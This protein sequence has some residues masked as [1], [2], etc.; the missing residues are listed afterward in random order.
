[1]CGRKPGA[2]GHLKIAA[3]ILSADFSN[4]ASELASVTEEV[5]WFHLD[6]MDGHFVPNLTLGPPV[7]ASLR[8][9]SDRFFDCHLMIENP[10]HYLEAFHRA[11]ADSCTVHLEVGH[12]AE[13]IALARN[14][15]MRVAVAANPD[16]P[17]DSIAP[18]LGEVDM[19]LLMTV[20]PG[21]GGQRFI[22]DVM[23]KVT[24][25]RRE[26]EQL[27]IPLDVQVDG[28][29]D[30]VTAPVAYAAG[31]NVLVAGSAIFGQPDP[32]LAADSIRKN[33]AGG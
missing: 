32:R 2:A 21:F 16:T 9:T 24:Q 33:A 29:I 11:G 10:H 3:S 28:G 25:V 5:D 7:V 20:F 31:A 22:A 19:V 18:F 4:L 12:T 8:P 1:M 15:G 26:L 13:A 27:G 23:P 17:F 6:V 30:P 14:L